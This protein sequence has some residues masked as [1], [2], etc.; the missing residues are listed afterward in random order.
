MSGADGSADHGHPGAC[1]VQVNAVTL[2]ESSSPPDYSLTGL[3]ALPV[4]CR[5]YPGQL[6]SGDLDLVFEPFTLARES[7]GHGE[8]HLRERSDHGCHQHR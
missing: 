7:S 4:S 5:P 2:T 6:G 1:P 3:P 8:R